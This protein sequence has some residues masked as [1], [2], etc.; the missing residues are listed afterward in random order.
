MWLK[1]ADAVFVDAQKLNQT[2]FIEDNIKVL[3]AIEKETVDLIYIDP[4]YNS[5][6]KFKD[7][8]NDKSTFFKDIWTMNDVKNE[9]FS[10]LSKEHKKVYEIINS[11]G[12]I[13]G[14]RP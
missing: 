4:P 5:R 10:Y 8:L 7:P 14:Q 1:P 12:L 2:L 11:V 3:S 13:N 9:W 6:Q